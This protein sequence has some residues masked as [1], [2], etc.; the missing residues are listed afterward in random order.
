MGSSIWKDVPSFSLSPF[1]LSLPHH[2]YIYGGGGGDGGGE[3]KKE[4]G[5]ETTTIC[6][7]K[8]EIYLSTYL[9]TPTCLSSI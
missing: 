4:R 5:R 9:P 3:R 1:L 2:Q 7:W 8:W 6:W